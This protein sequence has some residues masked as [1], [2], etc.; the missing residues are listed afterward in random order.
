MT[1]RISLAAQNLYPM[2]VLGYETTRRSGNRTHKIIGRIDP[3]V[4]F[5]AASL[6]SGTL[7]ILCMTEAD[8][9][10]MEKMHAK[11]GVF[12]ITDS[13]LPTRNMYYVT[14][15]EIS[16]RLDP[17]TRLRW[18]VSVDFAEVLS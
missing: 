17:Q 1:I 16:R 14:N 5:E 7:Q 10:A 9:D 11:V 4:T 6:R 8:A 15:G 12:R 13:D 3:D 18:V 2:Y